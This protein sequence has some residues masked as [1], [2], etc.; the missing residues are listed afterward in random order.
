MTMALQIILGLAILGVAS[1]LI[2]FLIQARRTAVALER[3]AESSS[4]D[5][6]RIADD[7][8]VVRTQVEDVVQRATH[9]LEHP[10]VLTQV[11]M[12]FLRIT[13]GFFNNQQRGPDFLESLLT[14]IRSA[15][16]LFRRHRA[17]T[18]EGSHE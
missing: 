5:L 15:L 2:P 17:A 4:R 10:S 9:S 7:I 3:L 8:H 13:S 18:K 14:G 16:H 12:G 6:E 1:C 11:A